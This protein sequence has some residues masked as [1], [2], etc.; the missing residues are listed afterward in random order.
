MGAAKNVP[1]LFLTTSGNYIR[2]KAMPTDDDPNRQAGAFIEVTPALIEAT[3]R[4]L[5]DSF[6]AAPSH[7]RSVALLIFNRPEAD[8]VVCPGDVRP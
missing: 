7:A 6:D 4:L 5:E 2:D 8:E 1:Y 3:A